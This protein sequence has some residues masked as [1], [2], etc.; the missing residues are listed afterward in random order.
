MQITNKLA[1]IINGSHQSKN[2]H[3][4][5]VDCTNFTMKCSTLHMLAYN[6]VLTILGLAHF[7]CV[8]CVSVK[9]KL[10]VLLLSVCVHSAW[11]SH[12]RN[13]LYCV[14][15][16]SLT[17][18]MLKTNVSFFNII[19]VQVHS[20]LSANFWMPD[21]KNELAADYATEER[22]IAPRYMIQISTHLAFSYTE[23]ELFAS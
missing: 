17:F 13:D 16:Y 20:N 7:F 1:A 10:T 12:P 11:K 22:L 19:I 2:C 9:V 15:P 8:F 5:S 18:L 6:K 23:H 14:K 3:R 4:N 21:A